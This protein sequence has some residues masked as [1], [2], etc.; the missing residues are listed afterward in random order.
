MSKKGNPPLYRKLEADL[1]SKIERSEYPRGSRLPS[2]RELCES[3]SVST[4]TVKRA[5]SELALEGIIETSKG[6]R[7]RVVSRVATTHSGA[8]IEGLIEGV[9]EQSVMTSYR[10]VDFTIVRPPRDVS[11]SLR[12]PPSARVRR[13]SIVATKHDTPFAYIISY[14]PESIAKLFRKQSPEEK[15][16]ILWLDST[17]IELDHGSQFLGARP[18]DADTA[19]LLEV[20]VGSAVVH[21]HRTLYDHRGH[22]I[23]HMVAYSPWNRFEYEVRL[24]GLSLQKDKG[25]GKPTRRRKRLHP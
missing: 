23:E 24:S 7:A 21:I 11:S 2:E 9:L 14:V 20:P 17:G 8:S 25:A 10:I 13:F 16:M 18:A 15:P 19:R 5:L 1:R 22:G 12:S 6:R 3:Y 4:V